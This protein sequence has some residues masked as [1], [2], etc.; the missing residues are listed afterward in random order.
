MNLF[1]T[2]LENVNKS[3]TSASNVSLKIFFVSESSLSSEEKASQW[4]MLCHNGKWA[5][6]MSLFLKSIESVYTT[7]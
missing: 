1:I 7:P 3:R 6:T 2:L 4:C 5:K